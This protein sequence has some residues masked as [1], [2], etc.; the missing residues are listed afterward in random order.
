MKSATMQI[1]TYLFM[2]YSFMYQ[3]GL[4]HRNYH[5]K[6]IEAI[7]QITFQSQNELVK[8]NLFLING[9]CLI[10]QFRGNSN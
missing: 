7:K 8:C 10:E 6:Y 5:M 2:N 1:L 3:D 4:V 9:N